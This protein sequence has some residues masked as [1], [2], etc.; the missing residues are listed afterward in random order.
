MTADAADAPDVAGQAI[1][2]EA[3]TDPLPIVAF[4]CPEPRDANT[5]TIADQRLRKTQRG[6]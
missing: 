3:G 6:T 5:Q 1:E 2:G 4:V